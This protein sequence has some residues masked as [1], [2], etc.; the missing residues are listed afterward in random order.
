MFGIHAMDIVEWELCYIL[1]VISI[2][3][4][5]NLFQIHK[6]SYWWNKKETHCW[7]RN[8]MVY[9]LFDMHI[10]DVKLE[11]DVLHSFFMKE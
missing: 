8:I 4:I 2:L 1:V 10:I 9:A 6:S 11:I 5:R 3:R 7:C